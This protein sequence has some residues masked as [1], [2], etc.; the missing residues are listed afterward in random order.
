MEKLVANRTF[1]L[2]LVIPE[3]CNTGSAV[4]QVLCPHGAETGLL[5]TSRQMGPE[6]SSSDQEVAEDIP[7]K[8]LLN[9]VFKYV[10]F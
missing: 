2:D 6:K 1:V 9:Q 5:N 8:Q 7:R 3:R 10:C 4:L